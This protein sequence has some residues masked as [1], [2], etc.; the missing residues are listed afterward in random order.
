[1][2][3]SK[4]PQQA[5]IS[6]L[7]RLQL[8]RLKIQAELKIHEKSLEN[9]FIYIQTH[10][11]SLIGNSALSLVRGKLPTIIQQFIP[12]TLHNDSPK[13]VSSGVSKWSIIADQAIETLP[14][15]F[16]GMRPV[17]IA[18]ALKQVKKWF[19]K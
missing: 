12:T 2:T 15:L 18:L 1:M 7:E 6:E 8:K 17:I 9:N 3:I 10:F 14:L 16:K 11:G 5:K 13:Q 19:F 4:N